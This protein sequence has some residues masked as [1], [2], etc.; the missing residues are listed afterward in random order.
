MPDTSPAP[1]P[2]TV[3]VKEAAKRT[4]L[5]SWTI[6]KLLDDGKVVSVYEGTRR[7]VV[8]ASLRTY[9]ASLPTE[10]PDVSA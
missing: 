9:I 8:Y 5:S 10:R 1:D 6:Y 7:L 2:I 3:S 4:G